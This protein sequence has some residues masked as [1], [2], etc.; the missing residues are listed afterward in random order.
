MPDMQAQASS[1]G[2]NIVNY[3]KRRVCA[4]EENQQLLRIGIYAGS[5][6]SCLA[7]RQRL[8]ALLEPHAFDETRWHTIHRVKVVQP[9]VTKQRKAGNTE[10]CVEH[11]HHVARP[12][13]DAPTLRV[14]T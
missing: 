12:V 2:V 4:K 3:D 7:P 8:P 11:V 1:Q 14:L 13:R 6:R 9:R 5:L 10:Q